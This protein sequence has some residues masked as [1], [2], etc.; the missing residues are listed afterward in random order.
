MSFGVSTM[1][2]Y[3]ALISLPY[4]VYCE[5]D[6]GDRSQAV[7]RVQSRGCAVKDAGRIRR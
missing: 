2:L 3:I 6:G 5:S 4:P 1:I 7:S